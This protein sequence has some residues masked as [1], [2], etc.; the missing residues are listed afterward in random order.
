[1][2]YNTM[3]PFVILFL[4]VHT[5]LIRHAS[6]LYSWGQGKAFSGVKAKANAL[7]DGC[8]K[9]GIIKFRQSAALNGISAYEIEMTI[10]AYRAKSD[11]NTPGHGPSRDQTYIDDSAP[12]GAEDIN[13]SQG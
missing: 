4:E 6:N 5:L 2:V 1:M 9:L 8:L 10:A 3:Y 12:D 11:I 13:E 7:I